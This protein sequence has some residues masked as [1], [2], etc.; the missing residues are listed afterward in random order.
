MTFRYRALGAGEIEQPKTAGC[1]A[2]AER[3]EKKKGKCGGTEGMD[4]GK[5]RATRLMESD[6]SYSSL[7]HART[8]TRLIVRELERGRLSVIN[9]RKDEA[10]P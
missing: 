5:S 4:Q 3:N 1:R 2:D 7:P 6:V 10:R 8:S 9:A